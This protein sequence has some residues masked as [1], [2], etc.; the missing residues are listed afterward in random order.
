MKNSPFFQIEKSTLYPGVQIPTKL[1]IGRMGLLLNNRKTILGRKIRYKLVNV[2][3]PSPGVG[4]I[5]KETGPFVNV[6]AAQ[7]KKI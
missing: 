5:T 6:G 1:L 3:Q 7:P 2:M 4:A